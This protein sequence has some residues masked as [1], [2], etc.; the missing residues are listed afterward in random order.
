MAPGA[1]TIGRP[2]APPDA[3][4]APL[5]AGPAPPLGP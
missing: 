1:T 5:D 4:G 2:V 3:G